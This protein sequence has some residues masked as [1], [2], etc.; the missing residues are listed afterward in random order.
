MGSSE[1][2][3]SEILSLSF[4]KVSVL[5]R[6][7]T[8]TGSKPEPGTARWV[9]S[10]LP[11][12]NYSQSNASWA[13]LLEMETSD[14]DNGDHKTPNA[15]HSWKIER[16][17]KALNGTRKYGI[18]NSKTYND[19]IPT[20]ISTFVPSHISQVIPSPTAAATQAGARTTPS[21]PY[22]DLTRFAGELKDIPHMVQDGF[23]LLNAFRASNR[24]PQ[25]IARYLSG[26]RG[27]RDGAGIYLGYEFGYKPLFQDLYR[28]FTFAKQTE[29]RLDELNR[30][31]DNAGGLK[32][33]VQTFQETKQTTVNTSLDST[34]SDVISAR[35]ETITISR[36]WV[37]LRWRP[38]SR[39]P[40]ASKRQRQWLARK[41]VLGLGLDPSVV[42]Q[43]MPWTWMADWFSTAGANL[44]AN[45][46]RVPCHA[47]D[48]CVMTERK[49]SVA[50][51]PTT[52]PEYGGAGSYA[53]VTDKD[54]VVSATF[55]TT[56]TLP[57]IDSWRASILGS[58][59][60]T[61]F[62]RVR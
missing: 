45:N 2:K 24:S 41:A 9:V 15:F 4:S 35:R 50:W 58:L 53:K 32:R 30:M 39:L 11:D 10:G 21:R 40:S 27:A 38:S 60:A 62:S 34:M 57:I 20:G 19:W 1:S 29:Q 56:A 54:R 31:Y 47:T 28:M 46:N 55:G 13:P 22:V 17:I 26:L 43:L 7:R 23:R 36:Q 61:R 51:V 25:A 12:T 33:K 48:I 44:R 8:R 49:T 6:V 18:A 37:T 3:D 14:V 52:F 59:A 42:Y 16:S 5:A